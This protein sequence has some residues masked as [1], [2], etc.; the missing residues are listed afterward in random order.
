[1]AWVLLEVPAW[2]R[3]KVCVCLFG[4]QGLEWKECFSKV[5]VCM[6]R[7]SGLRSGV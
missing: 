6:S 4:V 2:A 3:C 7:V 1:V 5:C